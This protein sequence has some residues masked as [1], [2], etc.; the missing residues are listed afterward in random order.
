[1]ETQTTFFKKILVEELLTPD[2]IES[3]NGN[4]GSVSK[5][6]NKPGRK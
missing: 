6:K 2:I 5:Q 1:M 4:K 3:L